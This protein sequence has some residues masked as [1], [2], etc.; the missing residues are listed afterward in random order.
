[1]N[2]S[3]KVVFGLLGGLALFLYGMTMMSESLQKAAGERMKA[4]LAMLTRNPILGVI[5]GALVT[6]VLQSSSATTVM[7]IGF[8]SAGLMTLP[9]GISVI[10]G[11]NIGTTMTAQIIAFKLSDYIYIIIFAGFLLSFFAKQQ[12]IKYV[13]DTILSF[14]LLFLGIDIMGSVMKPLASSPFFT[15]LI[16]RVSRYPVLGVAVGTMMT[17]VVQSS[18]ATIAVLQNFASQAAPDGVSS[19]LGLTGAIP[20]LLGDNIGTT[21]TAILASL[22]QSRDAKRAA[23]AHCIFNVSGT[24]LFIWFIK[25]YAAF[26]R[27]ISTK[28]PE[29][30]VISRQI[31]NAHTG[32]NITMV[33]IWTP[34][35]GLM[36]KIVMQ[37]LPDK[38][39]AAA[40][41]GSAAV[42]T[43]P[44]AI[45]AGEPVSPDVITASAASELMTSPLFTD[46]KLISQ[47]V[48]ALH[49]IAGE[50]GKCTW[51]LSQTFTAFTS[52]NAKNIWQTLI[53]IRKLTGL[54]Q[55]LNKKIADCLAS[56]FSEGVMNEEQAAKASG[57]L[58]ALGDLDRVAAMSSEIMENIASNR[59]AK[60]VYSKDALKDLRKAVSVL[61]EMYEKVRPALLSGD[62]SGL[63]DLQETRESIRQLSE[64]MRVEHMKRVRKGKC[65][66]S[67]TESW[68][69]LLQNIDRI[70]NSCLNLADAAQEGALAG[71]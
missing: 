51:L 36:V 15:D 60:H 29:V 22:R 27:M 58:F 67:L 9:Q 59:N 37:I 25:P 1:M 65:A 57:V 43:V 39:P 18:S 40:G 13:G 2:E 47:P 35:L 14:G 52:M 53:D 56:M 10:F 3:V 7:V 49:L 32:F 46:E 21:I 34:L 50:I 11:A 12:K 16:A 42:S 54:E 24:L 66:G 45:P 20:I 5:S 55:Q 61:S 26:I 23:A 62:L 70:G 71:L 41:I 48:A 19:I 63:Q 30:D 69:E 33:L 4:V 68:N 17:L 6:A 31:A 8:I 64:K 38:R 28:G 44:A